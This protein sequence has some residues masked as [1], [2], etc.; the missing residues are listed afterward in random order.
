MARMTTDSVRFR[1]FGSMGVDSAMES[2][3]LGPPK[4]RAVLAVLLLHANEI[5]PT[6]RIID[7][8]WGESPPRTAEHSVQIYISNLRKLLSDGEQPDLIETRPPGYLLNVSPDAVDALRFERLV[9]EGVAAVRAGDLAGGG[10]MLKKALAVWTATP[11]A[12]FAYDDFA[13]GYISS[14]HE[15]RLDALEAFAGV[16]LDQANLEEARDLARRA[17]EGDPLREEPRRVMMLTLYQSGRQAEALRHYGDYKRLLGEELGLEPSEH[18]RDLEERVLLQDPTLS[19]PAPTKVANNPYRGLRPF[20]EGDADFYFGRETLVAEVLE[21]LDGG[22]G[23]V[24][25]VGPSGSGKSSAARAGVIPALRTRGEAV[26]LFTPGPRPLRELASALDRAGFG[27][28]ATLLRRFQA[29]PRALAVTISRPTVMVIDQFEELF[30]LADP[31]MVTRFSELVATAVEDQ[32]TPLRLVATLRADYYDKPLSISSLAGVFSDSLVSVKPMTAQE[33]ERAMVEPA[34]A[35]GV[36]VEPALLAQVVADMGGEPG[37][38]PI[39]QFTLFELFERTSNGLTLTH[40]QELGGLQGALTSRADELLEELDNEGRDLVEQLMVRMIRKVRSASTARPVPLRDL[41]DLGVDPVALQAVLD[42]FGSRRLLT[43]DRDASGAVVVEIAHEYLITEWPQL[44]SWIDEH[45]E[46]LDRLSALDA[47]T[48]EWVTA[49][50]SQ[51][52]L[53]RG[54]RLKGFEDWR[55]ETTLRLTNGE[56]EFLEASVALRDGPEPPPDVILWSASEDYSFGRL[57]STGLNQAVEKHG[58]I[59]EHFIDDV[60]RVMNLANVEDRLST[61]TLLAVLSAALRGEPAVHQLIED[62]P[63]TF[64]LWLDC[65]D[66]L[67]VEVVRPN[68]T[69]IVS[70]HEELGFLAGVAA[71]HKTAAGHVGIVVGVDAP[72]MHPFHEGFEQGAS[73]VD[74]SIRVSHVY[75]SQFGD[76]FGSETLGGMGARVL[77]DE[78]ADVVFHAAGRSGVGVFDAIHA[79]SVRTGRSLWA[80]GVDED[81]YA[82]FEAWKAEPWARQIPLAGW[83]ARTLTSIVKRLDVVVF[84]VV[85]NFLTTGEVGDVSI[86]IES[87]GIDYVT[88]GGFVDDIVPKLEAAKEDVRN[89]SFRLVLHGVDEV[90]YVQDLVAP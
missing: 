33:I 71:A 4:Q 89:A 44:V 76:G 83:Q 58:V 12:E 7:L 31:D 70:R 63:D 66:S 39:L 41:L 21:K 77:I 25:I 24:S 42:A 61:G 15:L 16:H 79:E 51:D 84:E 30:T 62:H 5:V 81:E 35:A 90:R 57:I 50:R 20:S 45:T 18:L 2:V 86:S 40:Y 37:A 17:I 27:A 80:I 85:D 47:A 68:E 32:G 14:L 11:L 1:L 23:F 38:L 60:G 26:V 74:P 29:D 34:R 72:F 49:D 13:Q 19:P 88:T 48:E 53:L 10:P 59:A 9:R 67:I 75:L 65:Q 64:F 73:Y 28:K 52:Y 56:V 3:D 69:C 87:G 36:D 22:S 55:A 82:K 78:G 54:E 43:F 6:D 8:V 46:D